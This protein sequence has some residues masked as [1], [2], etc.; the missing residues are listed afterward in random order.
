MNKGSFEVIKRQI[1]ESLSIMLCVSN[2]GLTANSSFNAALTL[3]E[4]VL[5][6][7]IDTVVASTIYVLTNEREQ[8]IEQC[9][10]AHIT[11][12]PTF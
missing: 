6:I 9:E 11:V 7:V 3:T 12:H 8:I 4:K 5:V 2:A 1:N 10:L